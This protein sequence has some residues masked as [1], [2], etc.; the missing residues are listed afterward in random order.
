MLIIL[1]LQFTIIK[2]ES[3]FSSNS[4]RNQRTQSMRTQPSSS[5]STFSRNIE[6]ESEPQAGTSDVKPVINAHIEETDIQPLIEESKRVRFNNLPILVD[7]MAMTQSEHLN[8]T[9]DGVF[10]RAFRYGGTAAV[11]SAI[12]IAAKQFLFQNNNIQT[13]YTTEAD[14]DDDIINPI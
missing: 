9:R 8:P 3:I 10:A 7:P 6:S 1:I 13:Q 4:A 12:G 2:V 11:G 5:K 14:S